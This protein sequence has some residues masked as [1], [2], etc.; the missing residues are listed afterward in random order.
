MLRNFNNKIHMFRHSWFK[1]FSPTGLC[2]VLCNCYIVHKTL[3]FALCYNNIIKLTLYREFKVYPKKDRIHLFD[4]NPMRYY[5]KPWN[6]INTCIC[7]S[8]N[9]SQKSQSMR[10]KVIVCLSLY[11]ALIPGSLHVWK[12][13][14]S[15]STFLDYCHYLC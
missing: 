10:D 14:D 13:N 8:Q 11:A 5:I 3:P 15:L 6:L 7:I 12:N 4:V 9:R 2:N 1:F